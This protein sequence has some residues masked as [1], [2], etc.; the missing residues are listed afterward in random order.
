MKYQI[1]PEF[2]SVEISSANN[3]QSRQAT[4]Q[5][6]ALFALCRPDRLLE[7]AWKFTVFDKGV[8]KIARY[9]QYFVIKSALDRV[10]RFDSSGSRKGGIV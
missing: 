6:I 8:K 4:V 5:D 9:Q 7:L 2:R 1:D 10:K 3:V